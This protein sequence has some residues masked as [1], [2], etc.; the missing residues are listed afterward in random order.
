MSFVPHGEIVNAQYYAAYL[1]NHLRCAVRRKRPQFL[2]VIILHDNATPHKVICVRDT[3]DAQW[4]KSHFYGDITV[5][6]LELA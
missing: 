5:F 1:Q 3:L 2:N 6:E 4:S